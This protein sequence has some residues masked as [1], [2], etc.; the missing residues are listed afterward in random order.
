[1]K[2]D[3]FMWAST[4]FTVNFDEVSAGSSAADSSHAGSGAAGFT[5]RREPNTRAAKGIRIDGFIT[6][7]FWFLHVRR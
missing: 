2:G 4:I 1:V 7:G 6:F 5:E 3:T